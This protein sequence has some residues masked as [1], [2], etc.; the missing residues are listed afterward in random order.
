MRTVTAGKCHDYDYSGKKR[1]VIIAL[2]RRRANTSLIPAALIF[3][4]AAIYSFKTAG[5][6]AWT[7]I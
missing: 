6:E 5:Y 4:H 7:H 1:R 3:N 2:I